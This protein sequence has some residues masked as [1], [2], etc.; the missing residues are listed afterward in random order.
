VSGGLQLAVGGLQLAVGGWRLAVSGWRLAVGG[1]QLPVDHA[2]NFVLVLVVVLV[3]EVGF[4]EASALSA[5]GLREIF[6][7]KGL[8]EGSQ[9]IY[10]LECV[11]KREPSRR[12]RCDWVG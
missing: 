8:N 9:A 1:W 12:A 2:Q 5:T 6:V 10:C 7:P 11:R 4:C 3:L